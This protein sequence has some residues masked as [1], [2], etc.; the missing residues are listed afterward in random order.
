MEKSLLI[1]LIVIFA[2]FLL[3]AQ[4]DESERDINSEQN[5][6]MDAN[7]GA[8][9]VIP[10]LRAYRLE[11]Q[12]SLQKS[13]PVDT[14]MLNFHVFSPM[15]RNSIT[16]TYLGFTGAPY[17]SDNF[18]DRFEY[19]DYFFFNSIKAYV[20]EIKDVTFYNT[21]TPFSYLK[22]EE[23]SE[24]IEQAFTAFFTQNI[25]SV[26]NFGFSF[27]VENG[28]GDYKNQMGK[29]KNLNIFYSQNTP[30]S[31]IY[32]TIINGTN[33][34]SENGGI[35]NKTINPYANTAMVGVQLSG[36][37]TSEIKS[38]VAM[39]SYE[40]RMGEI[41]FLKKTENTD[42]VFVPRYGVQYS[43][44]F[45]RYRRNV[46][47]FS[48]DDKFFDTIFFNKN[49][50]R[51]DSSA[52]TR[53]TH[54]LQVKM[55]PDTTR[56][57]TFGKRAFLENEIVTAKHPV[58]NGM[59][60]YQ[61]SNLFLGGEI[62]NRSNNLLRWSALARFAMLGRNLG[63]AIVKGTI[64]LPIRLFSD[65]LDVFAEGWYRDISPDIFQEH[66]N[67]NHFKWENSFKK[68]HEVVVKSQLQ[69]NRIRLM[70]GFNYALMSN[71]LYVNENAM[72][73]QFGSEFSVMNIWLNKEFVLGHFR[74]NNKLLWQ[75]S[76]NADVLHLPELNAYSS[77]SFA[78]RLF[79]V[80]AFQL[81][82][83]VY[84]NSEFF[85]DQYQPMTS[86][87]HLQNDILVGGYPY[88]N[89]FVNVKLKRTSAYAQLFHANSYLTGGNYS[90]SPFYPVERLSF[91]FGILWSF[92]D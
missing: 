62:Y 24:D 61:Y 92:Y 45:S 49:S 27:D 84:Y 32:A 66:W 38:L 26:S 12:Y 90:K 20:R 41:P 64:D 44:D 35:N 79:K 58:L 6:T 28:V 8:V 82:A 2:P 71:Y 33:L 53:F 18:F 13:Y 14:S 50:N 59:R 65:T 48:V 75:V 36:K 78:S 70:A 57:F 17:I 52:F 4:T 76:S 31:T 73:S 1:L 54:I 15:F 7:V 85:A 68:Q 9:P 87:F 11:N 43:A 88:T 91:R 10:S 69:W 23:G 30:R 60:S 40:Y 89:A 55:F 39:A 81:G 80:L 3:V 16:N 74:W 63:D 46:T 34:L 77:I 21:N 56:K 19:P 37:L 72:P 22:Y 47:E 51:L 5:P 42:T 29:H 25:D 67:D 83:E 86:L